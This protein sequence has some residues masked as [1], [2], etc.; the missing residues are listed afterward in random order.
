MYIDFIPE[1]RAKQQVP[2]P[3]NLYK[4]LAQ[5]IFLTKHLTN[6]FLYTIFKFVKGTKPDD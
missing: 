6:R 4:L 5:K 2:F 3:R 1:I